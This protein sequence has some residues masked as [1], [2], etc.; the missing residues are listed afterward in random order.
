MIGAGF[1]SFRHPVVHLDDLFAF[2]YLTLT[3]CH[4]VTA[5]FATLFSKPIFAAMIFASAHA[6]TAFGPSKARGVPATEMTN[7]GLCFGVGC[8]RPVE[9]SNSVGT[10]NRVQSGCHESAR[11]V[12]DECTDMRRM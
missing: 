11:L 7:S 12:K 4:N 10:K 1:Y 2:H 3:G 8:V 5:G 6:P 9:S